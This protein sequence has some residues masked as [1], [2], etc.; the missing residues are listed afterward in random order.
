MDFICRDF[1]LSSN[2][3]IL[4]DRDQVLQ[5]VLQRNNS[6]IFKKS[7]LYYFSSTRMEELS[8]SKKNSKD[9]DAINKIGWRIKDN[10]IIKISNK[11]NFFEFVGLSNGGK[12]MKIFPYLYKDLF[13]RLDCFLACSDGIDLLEIPEVKYSIEKFHRSDSFLNK[14]HRFYMIYNNKNPENVYE[15]CNITDYPALKRCLYLSNQNMLVEKRLG[16]NE[17]LAV[18]ILFYL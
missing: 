17:E 18:N 11:N 8:Y 15:N 5:V 4:G 7:N 6:I 3:Q 10:N 2:S 9:D 16:I 14:D 13:I 1:D 12:I